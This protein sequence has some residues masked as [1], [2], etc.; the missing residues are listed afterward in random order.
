MNVSSIPKFLSVNVVSLT[1]SSTEMTQESH[2]SGDIPEE[3]GRLG[4]G[5]GGC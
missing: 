4:L 3:D 1:N 2:L 5:G